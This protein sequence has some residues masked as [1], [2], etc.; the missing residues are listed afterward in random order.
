M[1][2]FWI[3]WKREVAA[4]FRTP[5]ATILLFFFLLLTGFNFCAGVNALNHGPTEISI[6]E[7]FFNT[8][9]FWV[10][11]LAL[12]P[13]LTMHLFAEEYHLGTMET[14]VTAPV[15]EASIVL[16]KFFAS[17]FL[18]LL[19]WA[20]T[21]FYFVLFWPSAHQIAAASYG[22]YAGAYGMLLLIGMLFLSLGCFASVLTPHQLIAGIISCS[23]MILFFFAGMLAFLHQHDSPIIHELAARFSLMEHMTNFSRGLIDTRPI[24]WYLSLTVFTLFLTISLF[25]N[26][27][28]KN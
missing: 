6:V 10:A 26:C 12:I 11:F 3:L 25:K 28:H 13:L 22:A 1:R 15:A 14:L 21:I 4:Y 27:R 16:A 8:L 20:P 19:L 24:V 18:F 9:F 5:R 17:L 23:L 2:S 7:A